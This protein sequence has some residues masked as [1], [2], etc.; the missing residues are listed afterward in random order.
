MRKIF[1]QNLL[2]KEEILKLQNKEYSKKVFNINYE[3]LRAK[4]LDI[5][6]KN[7]NN[8]YYTKEIFC[9]NYYLTSQWVENN[10][11]E[12]FNNWLNKI[13]KPR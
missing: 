8:R 13:T 10:H 1:E 6:D 3:V 11:R 12:H 2:T 7:G 9:G 5:Q 4:N